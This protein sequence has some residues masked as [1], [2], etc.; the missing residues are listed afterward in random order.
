MAAM[1]Q[2]DPHMGMA[3]LHEEINTLT[4]K[5]P[6]TS[7]TESVFHQRA[8]NILDFQKRLQVVMESV[9]IHIEKYRPVAVNAEDGG[10][11]KYIYTLPA[12]CSDGTRQSIMV[13]GRI[14]HWVLG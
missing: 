3:P 5:K 11:R 10:H 14:L 2:R 4:S 7:S 12:P 1:G 13:S 9:N 6:W 8:S